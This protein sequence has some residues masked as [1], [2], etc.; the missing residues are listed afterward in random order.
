MAIERNNFHVITGGPGSGKT[1]PI[2]ALRE[3]GV[4]CADEVARSIIKEQVTIGGN[5]LHNGDRALYR[6]L[7]LSRSAFNYSQVTERTAPV[8]FDRGI[9]ELIGYRA[10]TGVDV[11]AHLRSTSTHFRYNPTVFIAPP[12]QEI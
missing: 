11:P 3:R 9:P 7:M 5:A 4:L 10:L 8:F 2:E 12:W 1:T 6:E